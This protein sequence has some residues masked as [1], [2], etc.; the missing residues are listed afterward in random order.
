MIPDTGVLANLFRWVVERSLASVEHAG[1]DENGRAD[2]ILSP[3][4]RGS[5]GLAHKI[6]GDAFHAD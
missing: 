5:A 6:N 2:Q 3:A 1:N 4:D